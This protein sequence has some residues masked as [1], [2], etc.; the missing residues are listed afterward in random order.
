MAE[1]EREKN[2]REKA[3]VGARNLREEVDRLKGKVVEEKKKSALSQRIELK[4]V[5]AE[6][7]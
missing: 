7:G 5:E 4:E 6:I 2:V 3:E 1:L